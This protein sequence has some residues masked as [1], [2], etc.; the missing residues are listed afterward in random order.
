M[1]FIVVLIGLLFDM[2]TFIS[3]TVRA[4]YLI[5][6]NVNLGSENSFLKQVSCKAYWYVHDAERKSFD[7]LALYKSDYYY[8]YCVGFTFANLL[9]H[10]PTHR[11]CAL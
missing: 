8:Y 3:C 11:D 9:F 6:W 1:C 2:V 7:I 5:K 4:S 10:G